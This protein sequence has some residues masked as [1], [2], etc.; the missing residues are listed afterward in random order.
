[1]TGGRAAA[2]LLAL[3][4][5]GGPAAASDILKGP[6]PAADILRGPNLAPGVPVDTRIDPAFCRRLTAHRPDPGVEHVPGAD[7]PGQGPMA[8]PVRIPVTA[9][10]LRRLGVPV[11]R[12]AATLPRGAE[13]GDLTLEGNR[14]LFNGQPIGPAAEEQVFIAC[15]RGP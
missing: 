10:L 12:A 6:N 15:G 7:L 4:V 14:V 9:D 5:L 8:V 11:P 2:A 13:V 1:M 3:A